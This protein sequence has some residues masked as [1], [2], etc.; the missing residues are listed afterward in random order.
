MGISISHI[1]QASWPTVVHL[2]R[3]PEYIVSPTEVIRSSQIDEDNDEVDLGIAY[4]VYMSDPKKSYSR[5]PITWTLQDENNNS[6]QD[7]ILLVKQ[8]LENG[9]NCVED[10]IYLHENGT[11]RSRR[12]HNE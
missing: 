2:A 6:N 11:R 5:C 3:H 4:Y 1:L 7:K 9:V 8:L 10:L 12:H